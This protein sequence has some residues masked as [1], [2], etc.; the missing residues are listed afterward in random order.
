MTSCRTRESGQLTLPL[1]VVAGAT[2]AKTDSHRSELG[3]ARCLWR[4]SVN[5]QSAHNLELDESGGDDRRLKLCLQ[6]STRDSA[7]PQI[8]VAFALVAHGLLH[9]DVADLKPPARLECASH[10]PQSGELVRKEIEDAIRYDDVGP[11]IR[12]GQ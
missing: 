5:V 9:E 8:D 6:Q 10:L 7:F 3:C 11:L 4:V 1:F 2:R 12:H